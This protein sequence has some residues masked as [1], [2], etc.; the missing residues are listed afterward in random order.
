MINIDFADVR[1]TMENQGNALIG[2]GMAEGENKAIEAAKKAIQSPLLEAKIEGAKNA[3][4]NVTGG[5]DITLYD[6][7]AAVEFIR[8]ASGGNA[9]IIFGVAINESVGDAIIVTVIATG[10]EDESSRSPE[11]F[12][13]NTASTF[14]K[15]T[16]NGTAVEIEVEDIENSEI[17]SF[18]RSR[19]K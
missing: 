4:V 10:F 16:R 6:S 7:G 9:D 18:I 8:E 3:I 13:F 5:K 15:E 12:S 1:T 19:E 17:P 11:E 14:S 2:I